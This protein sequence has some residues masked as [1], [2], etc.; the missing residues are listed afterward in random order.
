MSIHG[1]KEQ[2][3]RVWA[4]DKFKSGEKDVLV[5]TDVASKGLD[6]P[7]IQHVINFDMP[8]DIENYVHRIGR[9]GRRGQKGM[10]TTYINRSIEEAILLDLKHLLMEAHQKV[11]EFLQNLGGEFDIETSEGCTFCGGLGHRITNCPKLEAQQSKTANSLGRQEFLAK[12]SA[13]W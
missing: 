7:D 12:G 10:S 3:E 11:P 4:I 1:G 5:A 8:E 6:F 13:D 2:E 9:T